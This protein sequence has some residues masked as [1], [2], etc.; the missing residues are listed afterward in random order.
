MAFDNTQNEAIDFKDGPCMVLAGPG[1]GKTTVI[2][3]RVKNLIEE[4]NV[5]PSEILVVTFTKAAAM[6]MEERFFK[7][8]EH[9]GKNREC[10]QV[11]FGTFHSVFFKILRYAYN[12][13]AGN[14]LRED[15]KREYI[16]RIIENLELE[17][18]DENEFISDIISEISLVK[19][20]MINLSTYYSK[21]CPE[22]IFRRIYSEYHEKIYKTGEIDFDDMLVMCYE[23]FT[24]RKDILMLW[25]K[26]Y[27]YILV[28]EFQDIN[29]VQYLVMKMLALPENNI[30]V[31]GDDDQSIYSFRGARPEIM[32]NFPKE[33]PGTKVIKLS[34]NYRCNYEVVAAAGN[35]ISNNKV[36]YKKNIKAFNS[37][38]Q[39]I[40]V[41][42]AKNS[43]DESQYIL[44]LLD[45]Y[46]TKGIKYKDIA[47]LYRTATNPRHLVGKL[48]EYNIPF[49]MRDAMPNIFEHWI[50]KN[51]ISYIKVALGDN[52]RAHFLNIIN[53]PKRYI[54]RDAFMEKE[55]SFANLKKYYV[56]KQYVV[57]RIEKLEYDLRMISR[58]SPYA[59]IN[60]IRHGVGYEDYIAE[61]A[62][63]R[64]IKA[65][66]LYELLDEL[67]AS[68]KDFEDFDKWF[69][70]IE[71]YKEELKQQEDTRYKQDDGVTLST[72]HGAKGL[73]YR[74]VIII[75]ANESITPHMKA[76]LEE[77][78]EEER[79]MFYVAMTRAKERLH[80][81]YLLKRYEKE[82]E[83]SRFIEEI[84][85]KG[86]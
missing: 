79:R 40:E 66:E 80:I 28:D 17:Y 22:T 73:E 30:F 63:Y 14:I 39:P 60:Y 56:S 52:D 6:E 43:L 31:V 41:I 26:K 1:S 61:Y 38:I 27:K 45:E 9:S 18:D 15:R 85:K 21:N 12:Y 77:D 59:A 75:D 86:D 11:T 47:I 25:Q 32:L 62:E 36:R 35:L 7:L 51:I 57:D 4:H 58:M 70:Y 54:G 76:V 67:A 53:R 69:A 65:D 68:A 19:S 23:L 84:S 46:R 2:T 78:I 71:R 74:V 81:I 44:K 82:L 34:I 64:R 50:A 49:K 24:K 37:K 3:H 20:E 72:M 55:V 48:M 42:E 33:Y 10:R 16:S 5:S 29:K 83:P 13:N 8:M